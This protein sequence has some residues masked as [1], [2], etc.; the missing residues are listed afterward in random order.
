MNGFEWGLPG[1][2]APPSFCKGEINAGRFL[3]LLCLIPAAGAARQ[4]QTLLTVMAVQGTGR[5]KFPNDGA[6]T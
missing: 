6:T 1:A 3:V 2:L 5:V 4:E